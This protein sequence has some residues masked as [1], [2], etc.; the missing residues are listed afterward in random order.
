MSK[1]AQQFSNFWKKALFTGTGRP[2]VKVMND[3]EMKQ[4]LASDPRGIGYIST[5]AVDDSVKVVKI[6]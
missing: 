5:A 4:K 6:K 1:S 3:T 2:P